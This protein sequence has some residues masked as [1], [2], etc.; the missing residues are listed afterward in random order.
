M[1]SLL[2]TAAWENYKKVINL[3]HNDFFQETIVWKKLIKRLN[4]YEDNN[5]ITYDT[6]N[7]KCLLAFNVFR[8]WPTTIETEAGAL[9]SENM[10]MYLNLNYLMGAGYLSPDN[11]FKFDPALDYFIYAGQKYRSAG[12]MPAAQAK[13]EPLLVMIILKR[14]TTETGTDKY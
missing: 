10:V 7:L 3:S 13:D 4:R 8:S 14:V 12:E 1:S 6:I 9:D 11:N 5:N 2:N